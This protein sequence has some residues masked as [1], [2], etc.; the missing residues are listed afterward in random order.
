MPTA[1]TPPSTAAASTPTRRRRRTRPTISP[2]AT[3]ISVSIEDPNDG[4]K[5]ENSDE[6]KGMENL[7][8]ISTVVLTP[9]PEDQQPPKRDIAP[10]PPALVRAVGFPVANARRTG[11][12]AKERAPLRISGSVPSLLLARR[13]SGRR[14]RAHAPDYDEDVARVHLFKPPLPPTHTDKR[15]VAVYYTCERIALFTL[16]KWMEKS[17]KESRRAEVTE[18]KKAATSAGL[19]LGNWKNKMYLEV[20]HSSLTPEQPFEA[21]GDGDLFTALRTAA[22]REKHAFYFETGCCV[23]WGLT[24][25][26]EAQHLMMLLPFSSG[27]MDQ[28][29]AQDMEFSYGDRSSIA[30]DSIVL[31]SQTVAEKIALSFAMSQ[32]AT[33]GAFETRVEDRIRSTKHIPSSLASVGSIQY[34][35]NDTS[36]LIGQLFIE[37]ADVNIHSNVL[38]EPE[39]FVKSQDNDDFKYLYEKMLKYQDVASR[40]AILNK[41]LSILRDLYARQSFFFCLVWSNVFTFFFRVGVLNQQLTHHQGAKLEWIIIW[42]LVFQVII[43][44]GWEII[45][46]DILGYFHWG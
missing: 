43:A 3:S 27:M 30:K 41:R 22:L 15:R 18:S 14:W 9:L 25:E 46:K 16:Q 11:L 33:L 39:Y 20:L 40:V 17:A 34:S 19:G 13:P 38:D 44:I 32:S 6:D 23:F 42:M 1:E 5:D 24:R 28:V 45:L 10:S 29:D 8:S 26:E 31:C 36:K 35:Q 7:P 37:L 4:D 12:Q 21:T 2:E